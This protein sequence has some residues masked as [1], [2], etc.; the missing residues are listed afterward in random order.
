MGKRMKRIV[1]YML[2]FVMMLL[3]PFTNG[4][5]TKTKADNYSCKLYF[6]LP[7]GT[8]ASDWGG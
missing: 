7:D 6:K 3:M 5:V 4:Y 2:S 1:A 8:I